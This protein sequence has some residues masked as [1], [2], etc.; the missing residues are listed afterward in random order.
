[1]NH[2][3]RAVELFHDGYNCAQSVLCA[4]TDVTGLSFEESVRIASSFGGGVGGLREVCGAVS[5]AAMALGICRGYSDPSDRGAKETH[6]R[7]VQAFAEQFKEETGSIICRELL[8]G[9]GIVP[10]KKPEPRTA[11]YYKKRPCDQYVFDAADIL[12]RMLAGSKEESGK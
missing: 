11:D 5:G 7:R 2:A 4:F 12:D 3:E 10:G 9:A 1:M 6:Y 8:S